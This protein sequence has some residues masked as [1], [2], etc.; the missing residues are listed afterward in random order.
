[1]SF[2]I[3]SS[4]VILSSILEQVLQMILNVLFIFPQLRANDEIN[5]PNN[6]I[7]H[8]ALISLQLNE[9]AALKFLLLVISLI[10]DDLIALW[11]YY[12]FQATKKVMIVKRSFWSQNSSQYREGSE[13][14]S[15]RNDSFFE[16]Q[17][18]EAAGGHFISVSLW[19]SQQINHQNFY[20]HFPCQWADSHLPV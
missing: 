7:M 4:Y 13:Q 14:Y 2:P 17:A 12:I 18:A 16:Y 9:R 15:M 3:P 5:K 6:V 8:H 20:S 19:I 11:L 1:M 10:V